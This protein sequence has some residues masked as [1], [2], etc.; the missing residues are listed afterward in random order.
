MKIYVPKKVCKYNST[1]TLICANSGTIVLRSATVVLTVSDTKAI[2]LLLCDVT[3]AVL[4]PVLQSHHGRFDQA[5]WLMADLLTRFVM[6]DLLTADLINGC[7][8]MFKWRYFLKIK[9][10]NSWE[11]WARLLDFCISS[12]TSVVEDTRAWVT[13]FLQ[14]YLI[15]LTFLRSKMVLP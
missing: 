5:V 8:Q 7:Q 9:G 11:D 1:C 4:V 2:D 15:K 3:C 13:N 6:E 14:P 12:V 10:Y